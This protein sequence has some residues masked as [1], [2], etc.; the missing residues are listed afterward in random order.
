MKN[1]F[2]KKNWKI[3][4]LILLFLIFAVATYKIISFYIDSNNNKKI[5]KD[6]YDDLVK[7]KVDPQTQ[8]ETLNIDFKRLAQINVDIKGWIKFNN[9]SQ[10][11]VQTIDNFY[12]LDHSFNRKNN[13]LGTL[14]LDY[15]NNFLEDENTI[16]YGHNS[17]NMFGSLN[18]IYKK[19]FFNNNSD[20]IEIIDVENNKY[21]YKI[22]SYYT[23]NEEEYYITP[24][25]NEEEYTKFLDTI[26]KRSLKNFNVSL[27]N[28]DK[29]ITLSTCKGNVGTNK[30]TV[31]HAK[32]IK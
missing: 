1:I 31:I 32:L 5:S 8:E 27:S 20:K 7:T 10:P 26:K 23:I 4:L 18:N 2:K 21:I 12:Y 13:E 24:S 16:I 28:T 29:I 6:I 22:F 19:D 11:I 15:R 30:R 17:K 25:F 3:I 9:I 14:F